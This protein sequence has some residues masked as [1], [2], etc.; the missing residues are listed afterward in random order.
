[1]FNKCIF[2]KNCASLQ[3][4]WGTSILNV[5]C[6]DSRSTQFWT[7][8]ICSSNFYVSVKPL[9]ALTF[10]NHNIPLVSWSVCDTPVPSLL[11]SLSHV[12]LQYLLPLPVW[13]LTAKI[14][15]IAVSYC[16]TT[17]PLFISLFCLTFLFLSLSLLVYIIML[18]VWIQQHHW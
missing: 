4:C 11:C 2:W 1:M 16:W 3:T 18:L 5:Q 17:V 10:L 8:C 14:G 7:F 12:L 6:L 13:N 15:V 9:F